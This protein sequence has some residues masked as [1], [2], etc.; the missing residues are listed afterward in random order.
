MLNLHF[1]PVGGFVGSICK[2]ISLTLRRTADAVP[3]AAHRCPSLRSGASSAH[4]RG[5]LASS[6]EI[7][8]CEPALSS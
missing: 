3:D 6:A 8:Y 7:P 4:S 1:I 5:R 2:Q